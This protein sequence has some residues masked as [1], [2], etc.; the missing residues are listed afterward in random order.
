MRFYALSKG[1]A[2]PRQSRGPF[3]IQVSYSFDRWLE[4]KLAQAYDILVPCRERP[5]GV[6]VKEFDDE[7]GGYLRTGFVGAATRGEHDR[8]PDGVADRVRPE[9]PTGGAQRVGLRRRRL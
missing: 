4:P 1:M 3:Q 5:L 9:P 6:R 2:E 7:N 8:Q